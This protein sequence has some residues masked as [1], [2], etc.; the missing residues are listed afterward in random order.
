MQRI[1]EILIVGMHVRDLSPKCLRALVGMTGSRNMSTI[2]TGGLLLTS[3]DM[4]II[5]WGT[6]MAVLE[7]M[8]CLL[9]SHE[10]ATVMRG[11]QS[12][13]ACGHV[14]AQ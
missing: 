5:S 7:R 13:G 6:R 4:S 12:S 8:P 14:D 2:S 11:T 1:N 10:R 9:R 3:S